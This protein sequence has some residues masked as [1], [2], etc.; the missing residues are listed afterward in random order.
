VFAHLP[1]LTWW[2][3][4]VAAPESPRAAFRWGRTS[5][6]PLR[7]IP[8]PSPQATQPSCGRVARAA[9]GSRWAL[10]RSWVASIRL[11]FSRCWLRAGSSEDAA[12]GTWLFRRH[13]DCFRRRAPR[14]AWI[15]PRHF[16]GHR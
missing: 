3:A 16:A 14:D 13:S 12:R 9:R 2:V 15:G 6:A 4:P 7:A 10:R 1:V 5:G 11:A 8:Q